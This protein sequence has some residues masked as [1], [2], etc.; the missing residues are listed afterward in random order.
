MTR[1]LALIFSVLV[2]IVS[3]TFGVYKNAEAGN[4]RNFAYEQTYRVL[5]QISDIAVS[6]AAKASIVNATLTSLGAPAPIVDFSQS[7]AQDPNASATCSRAVRD[8]CVARAKALS[9]VN[10]QCARSDPDSAICQSAATL[11]HDI[12]Q[13]NCITCF[14]K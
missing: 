12:S 7:N 3:I 8:V 14:T 5:G 1:D 11:I 13:R 6:A 9:T 10:A 4:A 2:S